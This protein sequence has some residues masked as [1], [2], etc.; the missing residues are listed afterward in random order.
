MI[1]KNG[2][3]FGRVSLLDIFIL[4]V[5]AA[6]VAGFL[7]GQ[8]SEQIGVFIAPTEQIYITFE[9][10]GLRRV[11]AESLSEGDMVFR[12]HENHPLGIVTQVM[13]EPARGMII[14]SDGTVAHAYY[15]GRYRLIFTVRAQGTV[16]S[17]GY[18]INGN[19]HLAVG[20]KVIVV[21]NRAYFPESIVSKIIN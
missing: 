6:L 9:A 2:R 14:R 16:S 3:L 13:I 7:Y 18:F 17:I 11:N 12:R 21:S 5:A 1:D 20:S 10:N 19:D 15:E 8:I 4:V